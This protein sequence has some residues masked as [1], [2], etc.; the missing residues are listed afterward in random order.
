MSTLAQLRERVRQRV[1]AE[2]DTDWLDNDELDQYINDSRKE[3][4]GVLV[5]YGLIRVEKSQ[6]I[7][8]NGAAS[9]SVATDHF[10]TL[11]IFREHAEHYRRLDRFPHRRRPFA[12]KNALTGDA[13]RYR[14]ADTDCG[15]HIELIPRPGS[16]TYIHTYVPIPRLLVEVG[17]SVD[18]ILGWDEY[19]VIDAAIK[20]KMKENDDVTDLLGA[21][22]QIRARIEAEKEAEEMSES[23]V[24]QDAPRRFSRGR[25]FDDPADYRW[26]F[27]GST[28]DFTF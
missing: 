16:G 2:Q 11:D 3:L 10:A 1:Q 25:S 5:R 24:V 27:P 23:W 22:I 21:K 15:K 4:Y 9:Y 26:G 7:S 20:A 14:V 17:D 6:E 13:T 18:D 8:A 12:A 19:I 28:G